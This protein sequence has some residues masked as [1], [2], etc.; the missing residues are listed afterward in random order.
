MISRVAEH[1]F[2]LSR[3]LERAEN[4]A[5][6][7]E[8]N[9]TLLLDFEVPVEQQ[10]RP[11]LIIN[12][13]HDWPGQPDAE[14]VQ[15]FMTWDPAN[16]CSI[17]T[18]IASARENARIIREV[19]SAELWERLNYYYHWLN[20][21]QARE[22]YDR[23]RH[24]FYGQI[25]RVN[26]LLHGISEATMSRDEGWEFFRLGKYLERACQT[27]RILDVKYHLL[28]PTP[29]HIGTVIDSA[30]WAAILKSCSGQE[31][32]HRARGGIGLGISVAD[33]LIFDPVFPRSIRYCLTACRDA[34]HQISGRQ[35]GQGP[36]NQPERLLD[37]LIDWLNLVTI[38]DL[39]R[40]GLHESLTSMI[41]QVH[42]LGDAVR[43]T[44][45]DFHP[46]P[47]APAG[48]A[49]TGGP[50]QGQFQASA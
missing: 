15:R 20:G 34:A 25:K 48:P 32:F 42:V 30:H 7:L 8:V 22:L 14:S 1:C 11:I 46:E 26:Q 5:R 49:A 39:V 19:L 18:S 3:Y 17:A 24:E 21:D 2:W 31:T 27:G 45:F 6:V 50:T 37:G 41:D 36:G 47:T 40:A 9:H 10:W 28:L 38:D 13:I 35:W 4:T 33:F 12:G 43:Q 29:E 16:P 44:F 23:D